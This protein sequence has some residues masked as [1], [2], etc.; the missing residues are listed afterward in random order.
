MSLALRTLFDYDPFYW[1][2][3]GN[4]NISEYNYN[5]ATTNG[6][7]NKTDTHT[8]YSFSFPGL[9]KEDLVVELEGGM[10]HIGGKSNIQSENYSRSVSYSKS[11]SVP[12]N[13]EEKDIQASYVDGVLYLTIPNNRQDSRRRIQLS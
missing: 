9:R 8:T 1:P 3:F 5:R 6:V 12:R 2:T 4:F 11:I 10:L 7:V 13:L